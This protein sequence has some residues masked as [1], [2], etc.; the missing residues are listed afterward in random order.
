MPRRIKHHARPW[1]HAFWQ[2]AYRENVTGLSAMVAYNLIL[3]VFPFTLLVL[4]VFGQVLRI[5]G[6][7]TGVL[8]TPAFAKQ[9]RAIARALAGYKEINLRALRLLTPG[10][11][12]FT[13]SCSFH[14]GRAAFFQMLAD[15]AADSGRRVALERVT[16]QSA[17]H[18]EL[19][20]VPET[21]YL[22]GAVLRAL[23]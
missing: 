4:F 13:A 5:H 21:G 17:D 22:K 1:L 6:V 15:A 7:E 14:V 23:E 2:R 3:A 8:D 19:L 18:P 16:G 10:G 20:T 9:E 11:A 12:L